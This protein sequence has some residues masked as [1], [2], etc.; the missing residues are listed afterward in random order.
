MTGSKLVTL[1]EGF[2][3]AHGYFLEGRLADA[4]LV[5]RQIIEAEPTHAQAH[6]TL[7]LM[8]LGQGQFEEGWREFDW[9]LDEKF[10][11]ARGMDQVP[12]WDGRPLMGAGILLHAEQGLGD[13]IQFVR[14]A[15]LVAALGGRVAIYCLKELKL[16][17]RSVAGAA[18]VL[19]D[20]DP[21]SDIRFQAPF[22]SLPRIFRTAVETIPRRVP[23]L[24]AEPGRVADW[25]RRLGGGGRKVGLC[26]AGNPDSPNSPHRDAELAAFA[27][28]LGVAGWEF[29]SL[30][31]GP[32]RQALEQ[33]P[34]TGRVVDLG[35]DI[36]AGADGFGEA[37]A[38]M[39]CLDLVITVDTAACHLAGALGR[40]VW[41]A[42]PFVNDW[43]W[44]REREDSPW[45]PTM[46]IFRQREPGAWEPVFARIA[47][48]L[49]AMV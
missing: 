12:L 8:L 47:D 27:P 28:V 5:Y 30:Q 2:S 15:P 11:A 32:G 45:Y 16:L 41:L 44:L 13:N 24:R 33:P 42:L 46:R 10:R 21:I 36:E 48:E 38:I 25:R 23:Y 17:F 4:A 34:A 39:Q 7:A 29:Y 49:G 20:G 26:W 1:D 40:P 3:I 31:I 6:T 37:A 22:M 18:E 19:T 35:P 9:R 43:R 14:Y